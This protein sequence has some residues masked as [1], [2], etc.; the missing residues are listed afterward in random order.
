MYSNN[1]IETFSNLIADTVKPNR[2]ILF[3]SYAYGNPTE[4]SDVDLMVIM[5][6]D[7][8][9]MDEKIEINHSIF[10]QRE[11]LNNWITSDLCILSRHD[12]EVLKDDNDSAVYHAVRKGRV[13]YDSD[14]KESRTI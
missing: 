6:K 2:I 10:L 4:R 11:K 1:E 13:L 3:G 5:N 14:I 12:I 7:I 8:M 9:T